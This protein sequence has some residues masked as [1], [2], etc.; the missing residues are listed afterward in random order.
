MVNQFL[1][2]SGPFLAPFT[3]DLKIM[4]QLIHLRFMLVL[5]PSVVI[6]FLYFDTLILL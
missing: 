1:K 4:F 6:V 5:S 3:G 2:R